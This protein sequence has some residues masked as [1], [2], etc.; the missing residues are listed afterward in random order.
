MEGP[1]KCSR[2]LQQL[3]VNNVSKKN[4]SV[5]TRAAS[6]CLIDSEDEENMDLQA[7]PK[8]DE[9][10]ETTEAILE[11]QVELDTPAKAKQAAQKLIEAK[12]QVRF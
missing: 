12:K 9:E 5:S 11:R 1:S 10:L 8:E 2:F 7:D 4:V 6:K 3:Q